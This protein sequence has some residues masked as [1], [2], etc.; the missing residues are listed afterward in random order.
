MYSHAALGLGETTSFWTLTRSAGTC[1]QGLT[2]ALYVKVRATMGPPGGHSAATQP[3]LETTDARWCLQIEK[4]A[5]L[6]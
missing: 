6:G 4:T 2:P 3:A 1:R 5:A